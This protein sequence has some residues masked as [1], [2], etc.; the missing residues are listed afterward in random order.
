MEQKLLIAINIEENGHK[1]TFLMPVGAPI[2]SAY[3][4]AHMALGEITKIAKDAADKSKSNPE[5]SPEVVAE[6]V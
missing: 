3:N 1:F 6:V 2:G 5:E 4:A